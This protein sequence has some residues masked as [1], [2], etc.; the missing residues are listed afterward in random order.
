MTVENKEPVHAAHGE[1]PATP[2]RPPGEQ[3]AGDWIDADTI[4]DEHSDEGDPTDVDEDAPPSE[5]A[6]SP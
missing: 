2:P 4:L 3:A 6:S 5:A 1:T